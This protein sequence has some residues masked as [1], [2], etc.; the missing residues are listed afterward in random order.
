MSLSR[1]VAHDLRTI[2]SQPIE[3]SI[4]PQWAKAIPVMF[5]IGCV[6]FILGIAW[7]TFQMK[8]QGAQK[9]DLTRVVQQYQELTNIDKQT[10][11]RLVK[12]GN[13][14]TRVA[15]WVDYNVSVESMLMGVFAPLDDRMQINLMH[16][17]RRAGALPEYALRLTFQADQADSTP[18]ID[19]MKQGLLTRD[20][21]LITNLQTYQEGATDFQAYIQPVPAKT[22]YESQY[23]TVVGEGAQSSTLSKPTGAAQ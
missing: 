12:Q 11:G 22:V 4:L 7:N 14:A 5:Y 17:E 16:L 21:Q 3:Q 6:F 8:L 18:L 10:V 2:S 9:R 1:E 23:L 19:Q 15:R 13:M 20:W